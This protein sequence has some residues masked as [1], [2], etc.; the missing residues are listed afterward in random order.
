M[1]THIIRMIAHVALTKVSMSSLFH[2]ATAQE[3]AAG[4]RL[5]ANQLD[6]P[7]CQADAEVVSLPDFPGEYGDGQ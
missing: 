3:L 4:L 6:P 1:N 2:E 5:A 7:T